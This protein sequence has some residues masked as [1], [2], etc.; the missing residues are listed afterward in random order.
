[1]DCVTAASLQHRSIED[2]SLAF[3]QKVRVKYRRLGATELEVSVIGFGAATLGDEY[4]PLDMVQGERAVDCAIDHG[5]T[6]F[7]VAPYYGR[8]LAE[9]RLGRFLLGKRARV[10][11]ATKVGRFDRELPHG[12]DFSAAR[13]LSSVEESLRRLR[14]DVIDILLVHDVEFGRR[15]VIL[16]ETIPAML[17][18]KES[19][20]VRLIGVTGY[21]VGLL[22]SIVESAEID[23]VLSYCHYNLL[24]T[25]LER[26]LAPAARR[27]GV[28]LING[29]PLHMGVLTSEGPPQW[30]PAPADVLNAARDAAVWCADRG[31]DIADLG[32]RLAFANTSVA[33]TLVG[34]RTE[35]QVHANLAAYAADPDPPELAELRAMLQPVADIDW[36][37]GLPEN[38][39]DDD[40][41]AGEP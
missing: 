5:I 39:C 37:S 18:L 10:V 6:L 32:L 22:R 24:N 2:E 14:T 16:E 40:V 13:V 23:V 7:D 19:G 35:A 30:H 17:R 8:T 3:L 41:E 11:L 15:E 12:F 38:R 1:L 25:R 21:P 4:G 34:M 29:S 9:E 36:P 26:E 27:R 31:L 33:S 20:K 28:G